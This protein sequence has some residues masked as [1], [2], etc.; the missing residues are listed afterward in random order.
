ML[1]GF[2][3]AAIGDGAGMSRRIGIVELGRPDPRVADRMGSHVAWRLRSPHLHPTLEETPV[4]AVVLQID[5]DDRRELINALKELTSSKQ[6]VKVFVA[7]TAGEVIFAAEVTG[8][9]L[10]PRAQRDAW[11]T[12]RECQVLDGIVAGRTNAEIAYDLR[13]SLSTVNKHVESILRK[14]SARNRV[15][16]VA[17]Y[18]TGGVAPAVVSRDVIDG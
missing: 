13:V 16:A 8:M 11:L 10:V 6:N 2:R 12:K 9:S 15:Q 1:A 17:R 3:P 4:D 14:L 18:L 5:L 7:G